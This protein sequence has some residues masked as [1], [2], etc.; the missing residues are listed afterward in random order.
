MLGDHGYGNWDQLFNPSP[1]DG[2]SSL[3][4]KS[5]SNSA[6]AP[7]S[8]LTILLEKE[9]RMMQANSL[10]T[11]KKGSPRYCT[12]ELVNL[13]LVGKAA[14]NTFDGHRDL[15]GLTLRGI[16]ATSCPIGLLSLYEHFK[17]LEVGDKL[18]HPTTGIWLVCAESHYS[19]LYAVGSDVDGDVVELRYFDQ[20]MADE[21]EYRITLRRPSRGRV[22]PPRGMIEQCLRTRWQHHDISWNGLLRALV[23][24]NAQSGA[25]ELSRLYSLAGAAIEATAAE[26]DVPAARQ[27]V[28]R[29]ESEGGVTT[30]HKSFNDSRRS[31]KFPR[32]PVPLSVYSALARGLAS[33]GR[34]TD[35]ARLWDHVTKW[36][37]LK[38][39]SD[40]FEASLHC[41]ATA[42][43]PDLA[44]RLLRQRPME[45]T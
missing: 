13:L 19:L 3:L 5:S 1:E 22:E 27:L 37:L 24:I 25:E 42:K 15:D 33:Q 18:K 20:L 45:S 40:F 21:G 28:A 17:C 36:R 9:P 6:A 38:P 35:C 32:L 29:M 26:G 43:D 10:L 39:E 11:T 4:A 7:S 31:D 23:T 44:T 8:L 16:Q 34:G 14:S 12:Q 41:G 2:S 30:N